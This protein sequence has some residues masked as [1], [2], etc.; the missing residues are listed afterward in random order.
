[1]RSDNCPMIPTSERTLLCLI[2]PRLRSPVRTTVVLRWRTVWSTAGMTVTGYSEKIWS[3]CHFVHQIS[4]GPNWDRNRSSSMK[5]RRLTVWVRAQ[6]YRKRRC[7]DRYGPFY[8]VTVSVPVLRLIEE[9][10]STYNVTLGRVGATIVAVEGVSITYYE[11]VSVAL[12]IQHAMRMRRII[13][14]SVACPAV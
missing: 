14:S 6:P 2:D 12:G 13:L 4:D 1:M 8:V 11:R 9:R 5:G 3:L 7:R 10:R